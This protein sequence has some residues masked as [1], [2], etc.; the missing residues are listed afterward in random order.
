MRRFKEQLKVFGL[1]SHLPWYTR[2]RKFLV[3]ILD[4]YHLHLPESVVINLL[5]IVVGIAAGYGAV[6]FRWLIKF[7]TRIGTTDIQ[8]WFESFGYWAYL[9]VPVIGMIIVGIIATYMAP[10]VR[11]SGVPEV[12]HSVAMLGGRMRARVVILKPLASSICMGF[13]GSAGREGPIVHI[14]ASIGSI[15]TQ[16]LKMSAERRKWLVA[17]GAGAGIAA[18]FNAPITGVVYAMEVILHGSTLR[19]FTSIVLAT[20]AGAV[21]GR[22]YFGNQPAFEVPLYSIVH[23]TEYLL[24]VGLG[25]TAAIAGLIFSRMIFLFEDGFSFTRLHPI[26]KVA[27]GGILMGIIAVLYPQARGVGYDTISVVLKGNIIWQSLILLFIIKLIA[28]SITLG[29]GGSGGIFAPALFLGSCMGGAYGSLLHNKFPETTAGPGAYALVGMAALFTAAA[30]APLT[31]IMTLFELTDSYEIILPV[32]VASVCATL[33]ANHFDKES[34]FT[35]K[36]VRR[37]IKLRWG[38]DTDLLETI[39]VRDVMHTDIDTIREDETKKDFYQKFLLLHHQGYPVVDAEGKLKG[40]VTFND[41]CNAAKLPDHTL[42]SRF[43]TKN[44][45][46]ITPADDL[47]LAM[48]KMGI[49]DIGR[50]VVVDPDDPR[51]LLGIIT[52]RDIIEAYKQAQR[53]KKSDDLMGGVETH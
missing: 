25:I 35:L 53:R 30:R 22:H 43:C 23:N 39:R 49:R 13:G 47:S 24:Y 27:I 37:G 46:T 3:G 8:G 36:L 5:A 34:I 48:K 38:A 45:I 40:V 9:P 14:G 44:V 7:W 12:M 6:C 1:Y 18:T 52:R 11:G 10:E 31:A 20:V 15:M 19:S 4:A 21:V 33:I 28:T 32:M 26:G 41:F 29:S 51:T 17:C 16:F 2:L 50:L 42:V